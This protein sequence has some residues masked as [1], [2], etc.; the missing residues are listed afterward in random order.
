MNRDTAVEIQYQK[1]LGRHDGVVSW[2]GREATLLNLN[3]PQ[4]TPQMARIKIG[5]AKARWVPLEELS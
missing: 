4:H 2:K 5:G 1:C 3:Y